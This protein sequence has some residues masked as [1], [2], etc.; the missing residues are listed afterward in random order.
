MNFERPLLLQVG[1][2]MR[3]LEEA[4]CDEFTVVQLLAKGDQELSAGLHEKVRVAVTSGKH[5]LS[6]SAIDALPNLQAIVNF[7]VGYDPTDVVAAH[8]RG[9]VIS[10]TPDVLTDCVADLA[11]GLVITTLRGIAAADRFVRGRHWEKESFPLGS[12]I[13]GKRVGIIGLGRIGSAIAHRLE[14]FST[15]IAYYNRNPRPGVAYPYVDSPKA[16]ARQSD[17]LIIAAAGGDSTRGLVDKDVLRALGP[18]GYLV[19]VARGSIIDEDSLVESLL[20]GEIAGAGLDV[21]QMEPN[22]PQQLLTL[23]NVVLLPHIGS[24][25]RETRAAMAELVIRNLREFV[26]NGRLVTP[27]SAVKNLEDIARV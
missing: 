9:I 13:T 25:T 11:V 1:P 5:G 22:V 6:R 10:N 17:V 7:G 19:N 14:G 16:L 2:L 18:E 24:G 15:Q 21:F 27:I 20:T 23:D 12:Q 4:I 3:S 26:T 8:E